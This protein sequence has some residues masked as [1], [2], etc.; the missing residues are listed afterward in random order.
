[1]EN[2]EQ[3]VLIIED[4]E[5]IAEFIENI[6]YDCGFIN[7]HIAY[8][9]NEAME[10]IKNEKIDLISLDLQLPDIMG[11]ELLKMIREI[12][13]EANT[14]VVS[15]FINDEIKDSMKEFDVDEFIQKGSMIESLHNLFDEN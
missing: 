6:M 12:N 13:T 9:G 8:N 14:L 7:I 3:T 11:L 15:S 5:S 10:I 1:M 4:E 2:H